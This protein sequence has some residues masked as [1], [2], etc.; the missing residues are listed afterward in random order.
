MRGVV[1]L[2]NGGTDS[3]SVADLVTVAL[4]PL[5]DVRKDDHDRRGP[6]VLAAPPV[7][8]LA[9]RWG[10]RS[11]GPRASVLTYSTVTGTRPDKSATTS[12]V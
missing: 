9:M 1:G 3:A 11:S 5:A 6:W 8:E 2:L 10:A 7:A 12:N 4:G